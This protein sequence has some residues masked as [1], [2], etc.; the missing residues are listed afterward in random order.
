MAAS[1]S[2]TT[3]LL[4]ETERHLLRFLPIAQPLN[5]GAIT[6]TLEEPDLIK[7]LRGIG[8]YIEVEISRE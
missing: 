4:D 5:V 6:A 7:L 3:F 8:K 2:G 1:T